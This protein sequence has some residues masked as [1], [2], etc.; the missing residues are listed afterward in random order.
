MV[1]PMVATL[2][3]G[4]IAP[5]VHAG[6]GSPP[7]LTQP[8]VLVRGAGAQAA[9]SA[10]VGVGAAGAT[11]AVGAAGAMVGVGARGS[12]DLDGRRDAQTRVV[13]VAEEAEFV[14]AVGQPAR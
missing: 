11:I 12:A 14:R 7:W 5:G 6:S 13:V 9:A 10:L 4:S 3:R 2:T 8:V 1:A